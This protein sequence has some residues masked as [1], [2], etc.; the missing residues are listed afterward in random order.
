MTKLTGVLQTMEG[1]DKSR[2]VGWAKYYDTQEEVE[3]LR[4]AL[5]KLSDE[6]LFHPRIHSADPIIDLARR[7]V[8]L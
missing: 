2:R 5:A 8:S 4:A 6:I 1:L 7:A 3:L